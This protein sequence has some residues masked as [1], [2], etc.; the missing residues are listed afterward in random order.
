[1]SF[2]VFVSGI[3]TVFWNDILERADATN[4]GLQ[5]PKIDLNTAVGSLKS[6]REFISGKRD[7]FDLYRRQG[8]DLSGCPDFLQS[9]F[10]TRN[11]RL[12]PLDYSQSEDA[13]LTT[14]ERYKSGKFQ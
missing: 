10:H 2:C 1:M 3:Y 6:L 12:N 8:E 7:S 4:R 9:R 11:V 5:N 13:D 14:S